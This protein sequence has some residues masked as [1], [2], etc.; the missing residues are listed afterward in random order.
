[1]RSKTVCFAI[2]FSFVLGQEG[3]AQ[4]N[5]CFRAPVSYATGTSP[6]MVLIGDFNND[7]N[8]DFAVS[9][10]GACE[11]GPGVDVFLGNGHGRFR[12]QIISQI[13]A[14]PYAFAIGDF[15]G[16]GILDI[17]AALGGC[18]GAPHQLEVALGNGDGT[19]QP[20]QTYSSGMEPE[21]VAVGDFD[22]DGKIDLVVNS[23]DNQYLWLGNGDGTFRLGATYPTIGSD[24]SLYSADMNLDGKLDLVNQ[25]YIPNQIIVEVGNGDGTFD[26]PFTYKITGLTSQY[27][28][29]DV[30]GDRFPDVM[31]A[32]GANVRV[33]IGNGDGS[34]TH[35]QSYPL[36]RS[37]SVTVGDLTG[38]G[39]PDLL[40]TR[41][42]KTQ[43]VA[44]M[45]GVGDGTFSAPVLENTGSYAGE[46][47][48]ADWN[49]D[50]FLDAVAVDFVN[51]KVNILL[52]TG[53]CP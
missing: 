4:G 36:S 14:D 42:S 29:A 9:Y 6:S 48:L 10:Q 31:T 26:S 8:S 32:D 22:G 28:I 40:V 46:T 41:S 35:T 33:Y 11:S 18:G 5:G 43:N 27:A 3:W 25:G 21:G 15:N 2:L 17:A 50:G 1:M 12:R 13:D 49:H 45:V 51:G 34:L 53:T 52:N 19:F 16:D 39:I 24:F 37:S 38:D 20:H 47:A 7:G 30:N 44:L 23:S